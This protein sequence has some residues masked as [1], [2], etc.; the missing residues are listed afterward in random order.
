MALSFS[1]IFM[2]NGFDAPRDPRSLGAIL[3]H[4]LFASYQYR[5]TS[6]IVSIDMRTAIGDRSHDYRVS[7][8]LLK[9]GGRSGSHPRATANKLASL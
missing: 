4:Q 5:A 7:V 3:Q 8:I 9:C 2:P 6:D 1:R